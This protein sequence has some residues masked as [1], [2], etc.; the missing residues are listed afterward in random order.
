MGINTLGRKNTLHL[1]LFLACFGFALNSFGQC[2]SVNDPAQSFCDTE[3]PTI[4][5]LAATDNGGGVKWY[6]NA[7]GGVA[8]SPSIALNNGED[9]FADDNTGTCV[10]QPVV[11]SIYT[12]PSVVAQQQGFCEESTVEDLQA[13]GNM[14]QWYL[15]PTGGTALAPTTSLINNTFYYASQIN[16]N[17]GCETS[18]QRVFVAVRILPP[19]TGDNVQVL[20]STPTPTVADFVVSGSNV[21][22]YLSSTSGVEIPLSTPL[23]EGQTYYAASSD[24]FCESITRLDVSVIFNDPN[25]PGSNATRGICIS[26]IPTTAP[27][28]LFDELGGTP[29]ATGTW[30]GPLP[31]TNGNLGTIDVSS[32]AVGSYTFTY[33]VTASVCSPASST[34]IINVLPLPT[35]TI[36]VNTPTICS[37]SNAVVT[38][39][40]TPN[41]TVTYTIN[42]GANQTIVLDGSGSGTVSNT[43][44]ANTVFNLVSIAS[45]GTPVCGQNLSGSVTITVLP[46][47][48]VTISSNVSICSGSTAT[49]TF[50][51]TAN[52]TVTYTVNGGANQTIVLNAVGTASI[53]N[54]YTATTTFTLVS[55]ASATTPVCIQPQSASMVITVIPPPSVTITSSQNICPN[56][57]ATVTFTG[58]ANAIVTYT[59]NGGANQTIVLDAAG[60]A[61]ITNTYSATTIFNLVS[62]ATATIPVCTLPQTGSVT[63]TILPL[64]TVTIASSTSVC[65]G[66]P[67]TV[68]FTGTANATVTYT[69]NGGTNQ[70]IVLNAAGTATVTNTYSATTT[71]ALV[72]VASAGTPS[73]VQPQTGSV[74]ITVI[75]LPTVSIS[76]SQNICPNSSATVTFTGTANATV[77]YTVNGGANQ[78]IVLDAG[79]IATIVNNYTATTVFNLVS[80]ATPTIPVCVQPQTGTVTITVLPL[81]T[82]TIAS[83]Q[84]ICTGSTA[85]VTFTG[86]PNAT[87]T[88]TTGSANQTITLDTAG[89]ATI[90]NS[91]TTTTTFTLIDITTAGTPVCTQPQTG[92]VTIT[93]VDL[94]IVS[95]ASDVAICSGGSATVTFTGTPNAIATY[96]INSGANQTITLD[97]SGSATLTNTYSANATFNLVSVATAGTPSCGQPQTGTVT[98]T[99]L[100]LPTVTIAVD[101][102]TI[103]EGTNA[104]VTFTGTAD[105]TVTYTVNGGA[106]QTIILDASGTASITNAYTATTVYTLVSVTSSGTTPCTQPQTGSVTI[107][108]IPL[109]VVTLSP[110]ATIC[111]G[112][113]AIMTFTGPANATVTYTIN[114][115]A[116]QTIV[117]DASGSASITNTY[118]ATTVFSLVDATT[119]GTPSCTQP[120]TAT[121]TITVQAVP[122]VVLTS[123]ATICSGSSA[124]V[125]FT[126]TPNAIVTFTVGGNSQTIT[127]DASGV[128]TYTNTYS[129]T[130]TISLVSISTTGTPGCSQPQTG[131]VTITVSPLPNATIAGPSSVCLGAN[132]TVT[133]TGTANATV[134]Y[135]VNNGVNQTIV[136]DG[137]GTATLTGSL[138]ATTVYTLVN[139]VSAGTPSCTKLLTDSI[140]ITINPLPTATVSSSGTVC[141]GTIAAILFTGTPNST[142][143]YNINGVNPATIN[144]GASGTATLSIPLSVTTTFNLVSVTL[145][146]PPSCTQTLTG[147]T[148]MTV[149]Q[150]PSAGS[151]AN[152]RI[153]SNDVPQDLF[154]LLGA[155]AQPGGTWASATGVP[156]ASGTGFFNPAVDAAGPYIYTVAGTPPCVNDTA[157]VMV[158]IVTAPNAGTNGNAP[159]CSNIDPVDLT[160]YL[161]GTPQAGGT[162]LP[163]LSSGTNM[164]NPAVDVA[165]NYTYTVNGTAPCG[166]ASATV[167]VSIRVGPNAGAP[168][169]TT[170]CVNSAPINLFPLLGPLAEAGGTWVPA[171]ASGTDLFNPAVDAPNVYVYTL[172]GNAPCDNDT[173]TVTV[174]V[175]PVPDAGDDNSTNICSNS[176]PVDLTTRLGGTPQPGGVW[177]P[178]LASGTNMFDPSV[179]LSGVYTYTVGDPFCAPDHADLTVVVRQGPEAGANGATTFCITDAPRDL[180]LSLNGTPQAG[181]TWSPALASGTGVFNPAVDVAQDYTYTLSG[182]DPCDNDS[183]IVS[184]TVN[185]IPDAGT[186]AGNQDVCNSQ[187]TFDLNSLLIGAQTGGIWTDAT[188]QVVTN[189]V[190]VTTLAPATYTYTYTI[191]NTCGTDAATVQ[192]TIL[193]NPILDAANISV[194]S[195]NCKGD[196]VTVT[197][198]GMVDGA[199]VLN[200]DLSISNILVN[201]NAPVTISG[202]T[203]ILT[204]SASDIPNT[205]TTRV[206]F[207][208]ITN[209]TT[210]CTVPINP[211]VSADFIIKPTSDLD[212]ANL[213]IANIC[214]GNPAVVSING[215]TGLTDG[216]YQFVY[217]IPSGTPNTDTT[218]VIAIAGGA[219]QFTIPAA[220]LSTSATFTL[221]IS[222][223]VNLSGGCNNLTET[224]NASFIVSPLPDLSNGVMTAATACLNTSNEITL[225]SQT[226][227]PLQDGSY[228]IT[229]DLSGAA[230][231]THTDLVTVVSGTGTFTI[232]A[233]DL[234][235]AGNV[236]VTITQIVGVVGLCNTAN[237][238]IAPFTFE[239]S[240]AVDTPVLGPNGSKFCAPTNPTIATLTAN[241]T[242]TQT[243][244]W[245]NAN[246]GGTA[247]ASTDLLVDATTYFAAIQAATG[248]ESET[249]LPV[250]VTLDP[251]DD[252]LIP[253]GFSPNGDNVNDTF[254]IKN[255]TTKYPAFKL[256]I[257]NR[258]GNILYK[259]DINTPNWDGTTSE[260]GIKFGDKTVPVGVYFY[261]LQYNDGVMD[262]KQG[263]L[264]LSR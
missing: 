258:Y 147:S 138:S 28:N 151:N 216:N 221:T 261:I 233:A 23:I 234:T 30:T 128:A 215:A 143:V 129:S 203:G 112:S 24:E 26:D 153:C 155:S 146:N 64:P 5:N 101:N 98:I 171:L 18:R 142:V 49:V 242:G 211:N 196:N 29:D 157:L 176:A 35:A 259:G 90:A 219:G 7:T 15:S 39:T 68:T 150:P 193:T 100:P 197:F 231:A 163:A 189:T 115:G 13:T 173:A 3:S 202:G 117:L 195:P 92:S 17:T 230:T 188:N 130:T 85:T 198:N 257:F 170:L 186:S 247:Y 116:N 38:F 263:R 8:L 21:L 34:V 108:V 93:V 200:Y 207:L 61:S 70:T 191:T 86:T 217:S 65:L 184:V 94:P 71:F 223:I 212:N 96:T 174:I 156:L 107:T 44:T 60:T 11:V 192:F 53:T 241:I 66:T 87:V 20:C 113:S 126:G 74:V 4:A 125:T 194:S 246:T 127:L 139:V 218:G 91:Y 187:G 179:D 69:I 119:S 222:S 149:T 67:A 213:S 141:S 118:N 103:C 75:P 132:T 177:S 240:T 137:S 50:T 79:G 165:G 123:D 224:A 41:A 120:L 225:A 166:S 16:P 88:Y 220:T 83:S 110:D 182:N 80:V 229:Y 251:C 243:I 205:G 260:G 178:A 264:Y 209:A 248:C 106:N 154:L 9:Y 144:I 206:T 250:L 175:N 158:T 54:T 208:N 249:R 201:Q 102:T 180:F 10:R 114:S 42:S 190:D 204:I 226:A 76:G 210:S 27:F 55:V 183:A 6:A 59:I 134:T 167:T 161:G 245:Y 135:T 262:D 31:T 99:V 122:S 77:T 256:E 227:I 104:T 63:I 199:Y 105:A 81:P 111:F 12:K 145:T 172:S 181:G 37:G 136:L 168:A 84:T 36:A 73:C 109:P 56:S 159:L 164:F 152:L 236:T 228:N 72:S 43:Y 14:I 140:T 235:T 252:I 78:T 185:P 62:I 162:W 48:T 57:P 33:N 160:T 89:L 52:A 46:L 238:G 95:I 232:P 51:G 237:I 45:S 25:D 32:L 244:V 124:S 19:P 2:P 255:L 214:F 58:T 253:D 121:S 239:V 47:P 148:T 82:V 131:S 97:A 1:Y 254:E 40:G 169:S 22:W 133:F